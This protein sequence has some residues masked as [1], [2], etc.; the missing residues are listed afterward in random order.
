MS[1]CSDKHSAEQSWPCLAAGGSR[2]Q[3]TPDPAEQFR[4]HFPAA[5]P[6]SSLPSLPSTRCL[7]TLGS[8]PSPTQ[9]LLGAHGSAL[10]THTLQQLQADPP[11]LGS[12]CS[13]PPPEEGLPALLRWF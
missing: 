8:A 4:G 13:S 7:H 12:K 2:S 6:S 9:L 11:G 3:P 1:G 5:V 10:H